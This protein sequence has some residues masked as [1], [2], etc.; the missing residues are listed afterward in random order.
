MTAPQDQAVSSRRGAWHQST[1]E[2]L[3]DGCSWQY[4]LT[5]ELGIPTAA[6]DASV[7][8]VAVHSA[9][10]AYEIARRDTG[11]ALPLEDLLTIVDTE[12]RN[13]IDDDK[14]VAAAEHAVRHWYQTPTKEGKSHREWLSDYNAIAI[15]PYFNV[16]LVTG[17]KPIA[18]WIDGVYQ[19]KETGEYILVDHKTANNFSRWGH[20]GDTHRYQASLYAA[21]L[22]MSP[23]FP[24]IQEL[25]TMNYLVCRKSKGRGPTFEGARR[26]T[27]TPILEDVRRLGER[28]RMAEEIV[29]TDNYARRP[30]WTLCSPEWCGHYEGCMGTGELAG[31]PASV[32]IRTAANNLSHT[33]GTPPDNSK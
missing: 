7:S 15:E 25:I 6:K 8:G 1:L 19:H 17:A 27:V 22:V 28:I 32:R 10:E 20:D 14:V 24:D 11:E 26:V 2:T 13:V 4:F 29:R 12:C 30:E 31:T 18:G 5:Y 23:D 9:I 21:A 16:P 3:L 33:A